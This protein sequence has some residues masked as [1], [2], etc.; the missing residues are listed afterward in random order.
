[1]RAKFAYTLHSLPLPNIFRYTQTYTCISLCMYIISVLL[2]VTFI[3]LSNTPKVLF[4]LFLREYKYFNIDLFFPMSLY[5]NH[6][7]VLP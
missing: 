2:L 1:M 7:D 5:Y 3:T 6:G 4:L